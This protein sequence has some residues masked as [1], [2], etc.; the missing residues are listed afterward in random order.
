MRLLALSPLFLSACAIVS[1]LEELDPKGFLTPEPSGGS[2][3]SGAT[4]GTGGVAVGPGAA[5]GAGADTAGAEPAGGGGADGGGGAGG[6]PACT[7][8]GLAELDEGGCAKLADG[9]VACWGYGGDHYAMCD[10]NSKLT[11]AVFIEMFEGAEEVAAN[12]SW[13]CARTGG[14][15][16]CAG[17]N[18]SC[19]IAPVLSEFCEAT[20][21]AAQP[22][23]VTA[24]EVP[25][26]TSINR[27]TCV[28]A[29]GVASCRG[30]EFFPP[31]FLSCTDSTIVPG[32]DG[33]FADV[34]DIDVESYFYCGLRIDG[35][36]VCAGSNNSGEL[37]LPN[38]DEQSGPVTA[39]VETAVELDLGSDFGLARL[40]NGTVRCW[41]DQE[42]SAELSCL[43]SNAVGPVD[44][45]LGQPVLEIAAGN[46]H[47]CAV[48]ADRS[49][50]C[51]G[52]NFLSAV[53]GS[54]QDRLLQTS[55]LLEGE[56]FRVPA[57]KPDGFKRVVAGEYQTCAVHESG[58]VYC[59]GDNRIYGSPVVFG[60]LGTGSVL[61]EVKEPSLVA[62]PCSP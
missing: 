55:I 17:S 40:A 52:G 38:T 15:V 22:I 12:T 54:S 46:S 21:L 14:Q 9:R 28:V 10:T 33:N 50:V 23:E 8:V 27:V 34:L 1:G 18:D 42:S 3:A 58:R 53:S 25:Y 45:D 13:A 49:L 4:G 41:G 16:S 6:A 26:N 59:W 29:G 30:D 44:L 31:D 35:S 39:D 51:W 47:A 60:K 37:G 43:T 2:G 7:A 61:S 32:L 56:P 57:S 48:L 62:L 24:V 19:Q 20:S 36:V 5:G 11:S